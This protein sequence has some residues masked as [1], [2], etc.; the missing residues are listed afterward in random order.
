MSI[1]RVG[2]A[3]IADTARVLGDVSLGR[4]VSIWYGT[5]VRGDVAPITVGDA[6][7]VQDLTMLHCDTDEPLVIGANVSIGHSAVVH[8]A[9]VGE[10][11]LIGIGAKVLAGARVGKGC[12]V[13]AGAV[14]PPRMVV[15]DGWVVMGLPAKVVRAVSASEKAYILAIPPHYVDVARHHADHPDAPD[16]RP[17]TGVAP[18]RGASGADGNRA[19]RGPVVPGA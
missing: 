16:V 15:P 13:A 17:F 9:E 18:T 19:P 11:S 5:V 3:F 8:C 2:P 14:V 1:R 12:I 7:N 6:T 4:D 10:G